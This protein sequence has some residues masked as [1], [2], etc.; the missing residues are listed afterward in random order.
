MTG[1]EAVWAQGQ[2]TESE[3]AGKV[4]SER[5]RHPRRAILLVLTLEKACD[6]SINPPVLVRL[7]YA[8]SR[9]SRLVL[10]LIPGPFHQ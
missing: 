10:T 5:T 9:K 3:Y 6:V 4:R 7:P 8:I 1:I 2:R